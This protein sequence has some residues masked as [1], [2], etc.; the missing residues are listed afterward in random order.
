[1]WPLYG[2]NDIGFPVSEEWVST[3]LLAGLPESY[4]PIIMTMESS[5]AAVK[6]GMS[7]SAALILKENK[8]KKQF[9]CYNCG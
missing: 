4:K 9:R 8:K 5:G 1:M 6:D 3:F 7:N 2:L